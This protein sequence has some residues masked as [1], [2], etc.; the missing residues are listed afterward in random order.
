M[1]STAASDARLEQFATAL[2]VEHAAALGPEVRPRDLL[3]R[4]ARNRRQLLANYATTSEA[5]RSGRWISPAGEWLLDNF[6]VIADQLRESHED[7]PQRYYR[8][9]P[10]LARGAQSGLPRAF[11]IAEAIIEHTDAQ[12]DIEALKR[13]L[14]AYQTITPL[15]MGELWAIPIALRHAFLER[16][17][18][19]AERVDI[20]GRERQKAV[21][22][23]GEL[24]HTAA[25]A[26]TEVAS[27]L[28]RRV[29]RRVHPSTT[30]FATELLL[31]L[32]DRHPALAPAVVWLEERIEKQGTT[33]EEAIRI[34][35]QS[36][37]ANQVSVGNAITSMRTITA[38]D[39]S[40]VFEELS[41]AEQVLRQD[42]SGHY[43]RMD[44]ATRD[45]YRH[46]VERLA[47]RTGLAD[48]EVARRAVTLA[49]RA[50]RE[51]SSDPRRAHIG[52]YLIG[53]GKEELE[54]ATGYRRR[55]GE[56]VSRALHA[57]ATPLYLAA[58]AMV[59]TLVTIEL[60]RYARRFGAPHLELWLLALLAILPASE[61]A[62]SLVNL[63]VIAL[64]PPRPLPRLDCRA[65]IPSDCRTIVV[66][67]SMLVSAAVITRLLEALEVR[68][69]ANPDPE[70]CFALLTDF[71][72][73]QSETLPDDAALVAFAT[74]GIA[75]MNSHYGDARFFLFHR[76][77]TWNPVERVFMGW[78]RKRGK[79]SEFNRLLLGK[80]DTGITVI[81]GDRG[82]L[83]GV[84]FVLTLDG[85]TSLPR[86]TAGRLVGTLAHPLNRPRI[87]PMSHLIV[88]GYGVLQPRISVSLESAQRSRLARMSSSQP[89][90]DPYTGAVSDV[91]QDLFGEGSYVGKGLY[92]VR[93]FE[94][95]LD[96]RVPAQTLLSHD[97]FEGLYARAALVSDVELFEETPAHYLVQA[98]RQHRWIRGDWQIAPWLFAWVPTLDGGLAR[99]T[100][101]AIGRWKI[102]DNLR[103][104]LVAPLTLLL[105]AT[106]WW[107]RPGPL[108]WTIAVLLLIAFPVFAHWLSSL[109][110]APDRTVGGAYARQVWRETGVNVARSALT[111]VFLPHQAWVSVSAIARVIVGRVSG[112]RGLLAWVTAA[113]AEESRALSL[114][115]VYVAMWPS[116]ALPALAAAWSFHAEGPIASVAAA[117]WIAWALAPVCAQWMSRPVRR[118]VARASAVE[119][120]LLRRTAR[121]TWR[122]FDTFVTAVDHD[123]P[124]DNFQE[125]PEPLI[126]HRTSPTNM[127]LALAANIA[128]LDLGY[129]GQV[130]CMDRL[131][132]ALATME[133]LERHRGHFFNWYD[134]RSLAPLSPRYVSTVDS[135]NL[136][137]ML[138]AVKQACLEFAAGRSLDAA[139]AGLIDT[140]R[141]IDDAIERSGDR[142]LRA[143]AR[144]T[145]ALLGALD[146]L[147]LTLARLEELTPLTITLGAAMHELCVGHAGDI[148]QELLRSGDSLTAAIASHRADLALADD[149]RVALQQ[150]AARIAVRADALFAAMDFS[151][152]YDRER[153]LFSIGSDVQS[154]RLDKS[155][156][157]L[158]AS[159][160]RLASFVA[161]AK[162]DVP[163]AHW[164]QLGRPLA[165][166][167]GARALR[168]WTGTMFE[169]LMPT[170]LLRSY[171]GTLLDDTCHTIVRRQIDY[172]KERGV[173]WG[174][175]ESAYNA[176]D[177]HLTYQ[178]GPFG[179]PG[180]GM[181]RGLGDDL[182]V[183]PYATA[184][185]LAV[186]PHAAVENLWRLTVAG[187]DGRYGFY[188]SVDYTA[189]RLPEGARSAIVRTFMAHHAAMTLLAINEHLSGR[190]MSR[191]FHAEPIVKATELLLQERIPA[192]RAVDDPPEREARHRAPERAPQ[193]EEPLPFDV[194]RAPAVHLLSNGRYSVMVTSAGGGYSRCHGI[195]VTRWREDPTRDHW[196]QFIY[197]RDATSGRV[198][199]ATHQPTLAAPAHQTFCFPIDKAEFHRVESGL[200][201]HTVVSVSMEDDAEVR[202]ITLT[203]RS[204]GRREID[205]TSY[206][207][208]V[209]APAAA[210]SAHPAFG[211][212]FVET[213][214]LAASQ[215]LCAT[216]RRRSPEEQEVWAVHVSAVEGTSMGSA[217]YETDRARF[218]GRGQSPIAPDALASDAG[219]SGTVGG[220]LD[221]IFSLRRRVSIEPGAS[222]QVLF[223][224]AIAATRDAAVA[225]AEKYSDAAIAT[226]ASSAWTQ[227]RA[228]LHY[229][230]IDAHDVAVFL[231]LAARLVYASA[232]LR[233]PADVIV[234]NRLGAP[235]LWAHGIS[236]DLPILLVRV[237]GEEHVDLLREALHA[238]EYFRLRGLPVDVVVLNE[239]PP[240]YA[241]SVQD[242]LLAIVR[243]SPGASLMDKPGGIF[244]LR[245]DVMSAEEQVLLGTAARAIL[246]GGRGTLA[247]Q[248][249]RALP[250][251]ARLPALVTRP[252]RVDVTAPVA[253]PPLRFFNGIGGFSSDGREYVIRLMDGIH[254]PMPWSNVIANPRFGTL[255]TESGGGYEW[256]GNSHEDRLTEWSN[257]AICDP[258]PTA[259]YLRDEDSGE[260]WTSTPLPIR[261]RDAYTV[262]HGQ[263]YT[264]FE[265]TA[266]GIASELVVFVDEKDPVKIARLT[267][268]NL[269]AT[270]R[271]LT[272]TAYVEWTLGV[273][274][275]ASLPYV[276]TSIDPTNGSFL[277]HNRYR[278]EPVERVAFADLMPP[279]DCVT[280]DRAE[281][282]GHNGDPARPRAMGIRDLSNRV[283]AA[284]DPCAALRRKITIEANQQC[285][286][287]LTLGQADDAAEMRALVARYREPGAITRSLAAARLRWDE[288]LE[289]VQIETPD[290]PLDLI[291]NRWL[292]YQVLSCRMWGRTGFYQS[293][294]AYGFR[295][296]LQ[297]A[298]ALVLSAPAISREQLL[299]AAGRQFREG[300]V[301]HWWHP[302]GGR[303]VRTR[304]SDDR[305]WLPFIA[306]HYVQ[307]TGD[308]ALLDER[309]AFL[310]SPVLTNGEAEAYQLPTT[311]TELASVYEHCVRAIDCSLA[312]GA[313]GIP[314]MG[315]GDWNDGM[316][317][318][319][320]EGKGESVWLGWFLIATLEQVIPWCEER[321]DRAHADAYRSHVLALQSSLEEHGWDGQWYRRAF[322]DDG[323]ALGSAHN[324]ECQIDSIAQSW[325]VISGAGDPARARQAMASADARLVDSQH[326]IVKLLTPP[327]VGSTPDPGYIRAYLPGVR[328]NGGQYTHAAT[329]LALARTRLGDGDGA[330]ALMKL[331]NPL[332]HSSTAEDIER[333]KVEP[334]VVAADVYGEPPHVGRGGW[335]WYT[336]SASWLYRVA[337]ESMLGLQLHGSYFTIEP[338]IPR[339]WAGYQ[340]VYRRGRT[341]YRIR[342]ENPA[343]VCSRV[344]RVR[345]DGAEVVS[346]RVPLEN[347]ER[348]HDVQ[349]T[350]GA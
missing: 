187:L 317:R 233:A 133:T 232:H 56:R 314:L 143:L 130:E 128:A 276:V 58:I 289:T 79:L 59:T 12:L 162:G 287:V 67:P 151:F 17:A 13:I 200:E 258:G 3:Q 203:N 343:H 199:S 11:A 119:R 185:A 121:K 113:D 36:Q 2:A 140:V 72:D 332:A 179:V 54:K 329:W 40:K 239:H 164:F 15:A 101:S 116:I 301:Q 148:D 321:G 230:D 283:G 238:H 77:R 253:L 20:A 120:Y 190:R 172:G 26:P 223:T 4:L 323:S 224:T 215:A 263:G 254:T 214:Y 189:S 234:R 227:A 100:I 21:D 274:R 235:A 69:L 313:H 161:I 97:L 118:P 125:D 205:V 49:A 53:S 293:G 42:P 154:G 156:Y 27:V 297:D 282:L 57:R 68:Y 6:Y 62:V 163:L 127:G 7:L 28:A 296:Q 247:E 210:D 311:S 50:P 87:D 261:T 268:R 213:E 47:K 29:S 37:A 341:S 286:L 18:R 171:D 305:L 226:R 262:R 32:R 90:I 150:R 196:G 228:E 350:L 61:V 70:L 256:S 157:D 284:L 159:E 318:V 94:G 304:I 342:V 309:V 109:L 302:P 16:L 346:G 112:G 181:R 23:A 33:V 221:P 303:G 310:D 220:V 167:S 41:A 166:V 14:L 141:L 135:G 10:R 48:T 85:D 88:E 149:E 191:R 322:F 331:L 218:V 39:W 83:D 147:P 173:P 212:L 288:L 84:R 216:R 66:V 117:L 93:A 65:G 339:D 165:N 82:A 328:E 308:A 137:A 177:L 52:Y 330:G 103:R 131:E 336:G 63:C 292:L 22:L 182:V 30:M 306:A 91:Y 201:T 24:C 265:L 266:H 280:G 315:S 269:S 197:L 110:G 60:Y 337:L 281:F 183:A 206:A 194:D 145:A 129:L 338:C 169:Y 207:E 152:L 188:E 348:E 275:A 202:A 175:S 126:A 252:P 251:E 231:Q 123:L 51:S 139:S 307:V 174:I 316:N 115:A 320:S 76:H 178:Y 134:T 193:R 312:T 344:T 204:R 184:L 38:T 158:L 98:R 270:Q 31:R 144:Y 114:S 122:Y 229:L 240:S 327:F 111:L 209:L 124:P 279:P 136:A 298:A 153:K 74:Q 9:L 347:D 107:A 291:T 277:A 73:A 244:V 80:S 222:A 64:V 142:G 211:N 278:G 245:S 340:I 106:G 334:Y 236:G 290:A 294:G 138:L 333:Y 272:V 237:A 155:F 319:G 192:A 46:A 273:L 45:R 299:R 255:V 285:E 95:A 295:D 81:V 345:V 250:E 132:R 260:Y 249:S 264:I 259:F 96:G 35:H 242:L 160:S 300:D 105:L 176:R 186:D 241:Q 257:D 243:S 198:W 217:Q 326:R 195:A 219:L 267:L 71:T 324:I 75:R 208:I 25:C 335:T 146:A 349:V 248:L 5:V 108:V 92:D 102:F 180:L 99:N 55:F 225:L 170:L 34:E 104:S 271:R 44:F 325:S 86:D 78:E 89:G 19:V 246:I 168:S 8:E 43:P 1:T